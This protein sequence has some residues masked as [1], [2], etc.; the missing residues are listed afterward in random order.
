VQKEDSLTEAKP[1]L[2]SPR[3]PKEVTSDCVTLGIDEAAKAGS[4]PSN[5]T[6]PDTAK[7]IRTL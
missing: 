7:N 4:V 5:A 6:E 3:S 2:I 1:E